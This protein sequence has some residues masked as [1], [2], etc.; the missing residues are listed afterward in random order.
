MKCAVVLAHP[1]ATSFCASMARACVDSLT[2]AGHAVLLR[3]LY[4]MDFDPR[5][6]A[7]ELPSDSGFRPAPDVVRERELLAEADLFVFVYPF[8]F[9]APPAILKGYVDRVFGMKFGY[10][11]DF[12]GSKPLLVGR[13]LLTFSTSGAPDHWV[14]STG[15]L[16]ALMAVFDNHVAAVCGLTVADHVHF[17]G[18]HSLLADEAAADML[19]Q[20]RTRVAE[21]AATATSCPT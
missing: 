9:N 14:N 1:K 21:A 15:A 3:D 19:D 20:V 11:A 10:A 8:W 4:A 7:D 6:R 12:G 5:L 17:G 2:A 18:I 13:K 16:K